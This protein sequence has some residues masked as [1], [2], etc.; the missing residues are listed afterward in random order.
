LKQLVEA[1][2]TIGTPMKDHRGSSA[3]RRAMIGKLLERFHAETTEQAE[4]AQ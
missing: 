1:S 2:V 3:Y 4:A